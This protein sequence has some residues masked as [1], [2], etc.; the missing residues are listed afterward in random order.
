MAPN[1]GLRIALYASFILVVAQSS[2]A[3]T[4]P[5]LETDY[6]ES[7]VYQQLGATHGLIFAGDVVDCIFPTNEAAKWLRTAYH[8][9]ATADVE[10]GTGGI[11]ASIGFEL[12]RDENRGNGLPD[13]LKQFSTSMGEGVSMADL[14]ALGATMTYM[15]CTGNATSGRAPAIIPYRFGRQDATG[16]GPAGVPQP[17]ENITTH[18][19][20]FA[21]QGFNASEMIALVACGHSIG[22]IH[23]R[24]FPEIA[25]SSDANVR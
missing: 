6:L 2:T 9:M 25:P 19:E 8:D 11:D 14:I 1:L 7:L 4:W 5:D 20:I 3:Y 12:G 16:P 13:T 18:T 23:Q 17:H 15:A 24:D 22:G 10:A 21:K